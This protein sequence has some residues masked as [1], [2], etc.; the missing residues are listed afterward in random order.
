M[1]AGQDIR[2]PMTRKRRAA[3]TLLWLFYFG[4]LLDSWFGPLRLA[5][6]VV[7]YLFVLAVLLMPFLRL[8]LTNGKRLMD[9][10]SAEGGRIFTQVNIVLITIL[11]TPVALVGL[12]NEMRGNNSSLTFCTD[13]RRFVYNGHT[14]HVMYENM[15]ATDD[16]GV[17]VT[18][19]KALV[20]P[21]I[22]VSS[23][24]GESFC[25]DVKIIR[26]DKSGFWLRGKGSRAE[27]KFVSDPQ[28]R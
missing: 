15:G 27:A 25:G 19:E 10:V 6:P 14:Y 22:Y 21:L 3:L 18:R 4:V 26:F 24:Y 9:F 17:I 11:V 23:V 1:T 13:V 20:G 16:G 7:N 28:S 5:P 12:Y 2:E 8:P